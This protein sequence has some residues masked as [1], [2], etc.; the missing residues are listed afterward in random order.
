VTLT[1]LVIVL[2]MVALLSGYVALSAGAMSETERRIKCASN[3]RTIGQ[4]ILLYSNENRG[5]YPRTRFDIKTVDK[6]VWGTPYP[7]DKVEPP[8]AD[9]TPDPFA[10]DDD[11]KANM[12]PAPNDVSA[13]LFMLIR[14]QEITSE[15]FVCPSSKRKPWNFGGGALTAL[16][17]TNFAGTSVLRD[18]LSYAYANPYPGTEAIGKGYKLNNSIGAEF[19][20]AAD[21]GPG[22]D[23]LLTLSTNAGAEAMSRGNSFNHYSEGQNILYGDGHVEFASS[24]FVGVQRDN[25]YTAGGPELRDR[26]NGK[27]ALV[28][29]PVDANDSVLLPTA[30]SIGAQPRP[31]TPL[32]AM[33]PEQFQA[34]FAGTYAQPPQQ[35]QQPQQ[36]GR[37][38]LPKGK[39]TIDGKEMVFVSGPATI[40]FAYE[41]LGTRDDEYS[42]RLTAP[43]SAPVEI[44]LTKSPDGG[45]HLDSETRIP[46]WA[47]AVLGAWKREK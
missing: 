34:A 6:P 28:G 8:A 18:H 21:M 29:A 7:A 3:L 17:W 30:K 32:Q 37:D 23:A 1:D 47:G 41:P 36:P 43:D 40:R 10:K 13:A 26:G 15:I 5:A 22:D 35:P 42:V 11:P 33:T 45:I 46:G 39:L 9:F 4:A 14:T 2:V 27:A 31:R 25:I 16:N 44:D 24:P 12:R 19:A 38:R 20:I